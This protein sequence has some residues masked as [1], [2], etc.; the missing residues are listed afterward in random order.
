MNS[1]YR[2]VWCDQK[3]C[4]KVAPETARGG[5][6]GRG[7]S[8]SIRRATVNIFLSSAIAISAS[9]GLA[10]QPVPSM[11]QLPTG[12][13]VAQGK[14]SLSQTST[15][16]AAAL[17]V[18]QSSQRAVI[19]WDTFNLGSAATVNF[20]QPN[21]QA[22]TLNRVNDANPSQ[23][24]GKITA[25]GQVFLSNPSGLYFSPTSQVD[26]GSFTATTHSISDDNFMAGN[27]RFE[28]NKATG[29]VVN[30]GVMKSGLA[31]YIALLA[32][33]VQNSGVVVAKV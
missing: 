30:E 7:S 11:N 10:G 8:R 28:R 19:N 31:G 22:V 29:K 33:E 23:I 25:P 15:A 14:A 16:Q 18:Q 1:S 32:P 27:Y 26:V 12:G 3:Q 24:Y 5:S 21:A 13:V 2:L 20:A 9:S 4:F 17:T 6:K